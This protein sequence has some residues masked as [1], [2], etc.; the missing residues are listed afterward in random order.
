V[1]KAGHLLLL[2]EGNRYDVF[3]T[4]L[5][6][7][8]RGAYRILLKRA[9]GERPLRWPNKTQKDNINMSLRVIRN[10]VRKY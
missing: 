1:T 10:K 8:G 9:L 5:K 4:W 6:E 7:A 3:G 2:G